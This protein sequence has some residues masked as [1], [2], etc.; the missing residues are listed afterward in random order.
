[1]LMHEV[2]LMTKVPVERGALTLSH[3]NH[4]LLMGSCFTENIGKRLA[5]SRFDTLINPFGIVYNPLSLADGLRRCIDGET[6]GEEH[7]VCHNGLWHSWL[8]HG[9]FS[10]ADKQQCLDACNAAL[11][12]AH[13]FMQS[14]DTL[15]ITMGSAWYFALAN[16]P[17]TVVANCHK[18]PANLFVKRMATVEEVVSAWLPL[19]QRLESEGRRVLFTVSP[20]R[21]QA[22][23]AHGNQLGKAVLLLAIEQ[24]Q[25]VMGEKGCCHYF[26]A[27]EIMMDELRDYRYYA[28][29]LLHPSALAE[30]IIWQRFQATYM[31]EETVKLCETAEKLSRMEMHRPLH[32]DSEEYKAYEVNMAAL[33]QELAAAGLANH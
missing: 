29:D 8:H 31:S 26:P 4:V 14:C 3:V 28:D 24:L 32:A 33:R 20:V 12:A 23:G 13:H 25:K 19:L 10:S 18:V 2:K 22:Y 5:F 1:M 27:Y 16:A 9:V 6:I 17:H 15:L 7:L 11:S 21:H 30:E